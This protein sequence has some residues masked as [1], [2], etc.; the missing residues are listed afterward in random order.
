MK[1]LSI[2]ALLIALAAGAWFLYNQ[3]EQAD[4]PKP[5]DES[6][7]ANLALQSAFASARTTQKPLLVIFG[8]NWCPDCRA[9]DQAMQNEPL[10]SLV[11]DHFIPVKIDVGNFN[12]NMDISDRYGNITKRGIPAIAVLSPEGEVR[13]ATRAG[14]LAKAKRMG[15]GGIYDFLSG[16]AKQSAMN[17]LAIEK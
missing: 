17:Q 12:R 7:D 13:F 14:E 10:A 5:Y 2:F 4:L 6:A 15:P 1:K 8:A 16:V 9:L 3:R 11:S